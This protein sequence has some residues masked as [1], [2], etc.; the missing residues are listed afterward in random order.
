MTVADEAVFGKTQA[1]E[2]EEFVED[3]F[4]QRRQVVVVESSAEETNKIDL[5]SV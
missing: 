1:P 5:L 2:P 3:S 4:G